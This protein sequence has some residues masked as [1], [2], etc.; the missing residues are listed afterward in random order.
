MILD[1]ISNVIDGN[2]FEP[3][4]NT[5]IMGG[6]KDTLT[7]LVDTATKNTSINTTIDHFSLDLSKNNYVK[8]GIIAI[9]ILVGV[10]VYYKAVKK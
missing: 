8:Y 5:D 6:L 1:D 4:S 9:V 3:D 2:S 7:G 10:F